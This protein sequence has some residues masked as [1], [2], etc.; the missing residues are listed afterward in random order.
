MR[1][2]KKKLGNKGAAIVAVLIG[3]L[4]IA[5][6]ASSLLYMSTMNYKMKSMRQ[7]SSDNFYTAEFALNDLL[8]QIKQY[9]S[10]SDDPQGAL[11]T[12]LDGG[13]NQFNIGNLE[14]LIETNPGNIYGVDSV[15]IN[16]IYYENNPGAK[17]YEEVGNYIN[18]YGLTV[19]AHT[20]DEHGNYESRI[21]TDLSF[22]FPASPGGG[23]KLNDFSMISDCPL[24]VQSSSQYIG[25]D[26][27]LFAN[28][29]LG[30]S[31][32]QVGGA[33]VVTMLS[34][35][36]FLQGDLTV[37]DTG[38]VYVAG[39]T[40]VMGNVNVTGN[41][42]VVVGGNLYVQGSINGRVVES[43][44][45]HMYPNYSGMDWDYYEDNYGDGLAHTLVAEK[46]YLHFNEGSGG[47]L[48]LSQLEFANGGP[49]KNELIQEGTVNGVTAKAC[50]LTNDVS[51]NWD[52]T[53]IL[54]SVPMNCFH[55]KIEN[56]TYIN[57]CGTGKIVM[58]IQAHSNSW[59]T[60]DDKHFEAAKKLLFR[61]QGGGGGYSLGVPTFADNGQDTTMIH[62]VEGADEDTFTLGGKTLKKFRDGYYYN[63]A[64]GKQNFFSF[65][66]FLADNVDEKIKNFKQGGD[67]S[68]GE[69]SS[70]SQPVVFL[71]KWEKD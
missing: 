44:G 31:A 10:I 7:F 58:D 18:V 38:A 22:G 23:G 62:N 1:V 47:V 4:F 64:D 6:L 69:G 61:R 26:V 37:N 63:A 52:N 66:M 71:T 67:L 16:S 14:D 8:S 55:G 43:A 48:E 28:G 51:H 42:Q 21:T 15:S 29:S 45:G 12:L 46:M 57:V 60:M 9:V 54:S 36:C 49:D 13:S 3:I 25:G 70:S 19:I 40:Y 59:G 2:S 39:N 34:K 65:G 68:G 27:Y 35:Y 33:A 20:D 32:V 56:S 41:G 30:T 5:I 50:Y 11:R 24:D 53:L 17:T